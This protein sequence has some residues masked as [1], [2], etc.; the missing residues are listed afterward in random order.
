[1][2]LIYALLIFFG[3]MTPA[4]YTNF[5]ADL[6]QHTLNSNEAVVTQILN[7]PAEMERIRTMDIDRLED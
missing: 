5:D 1:M 3:A 6:Y 4:E 7:D 2:E